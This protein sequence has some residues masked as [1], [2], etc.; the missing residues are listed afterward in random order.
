MHELYVLHIHVHVCNYGCWIRII[1]II[2]NFTTTT[3]F[4]NEVSNAQHNSTH[5]Y[6]M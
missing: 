1:I 2:Y 4:Q 6:F 3:K 5:V